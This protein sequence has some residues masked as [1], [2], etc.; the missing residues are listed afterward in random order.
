MNDFDR[1]L[2]ILDT[3]DSKCVQLM[4]MPHFQK[5]GKEGIFAII[6]KAKSS[7]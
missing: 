5:M 3:F 4:K 1:S 2:A 7:M 6:A